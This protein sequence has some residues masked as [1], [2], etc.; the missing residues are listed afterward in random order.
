MQ[1]DVKKHYLDSPQGTGERPGVGLIIEKL[2]IFF[3]FYTF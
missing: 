1:F 2:V 3:I